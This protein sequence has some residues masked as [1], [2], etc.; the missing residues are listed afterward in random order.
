MP[1]KTQVLLAPIQN[2]PETVD[3]VEAWRGMRPSAKAAE[4]PSPG[5]RGTRRRAVREQLGAPYVSRRPPSDHMAAVGV[6]ALGCRIA[7]R[8]GMGRR[9]RDARCLYHL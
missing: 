7:R 2:S 3:G 6:G 9:R 8:R 1:P 4:R 5:D